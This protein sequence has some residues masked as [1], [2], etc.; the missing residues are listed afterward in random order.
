[1][2]RKY[3]LLSFAWALAVACFGQEKFNPDLALG[4]L[5]GPREN[6]G[7]AAG[8]AV[9]G[10]LKWSGSSGY[11][12]LEGNIPF[13]ATTLTRIASISKPFT[14]VAVMQLVEQN[15]IALD[16]P[17]EHYLPELPGDKGSITVRQLLAHTSGISQYEG[18]KE[19][20]N[21]LHFGSLRE[22][23]AIFIQRP[24]LFEPGSQYFYTTYGY[25]VL[26]RI[27]EAVS[28]MGYREYMKKYVFEVA[29]MGDTD[30]E[31]LREAYPNK[32]CLYHH[33]GRKTREAR[34][35]DLSNRIPGGGF[36]ST[37]EDVL[38]FGNALLEGKLIRRE[39][40]DLMVQ[41]QDV[42]YDGNK[43]GLGWYLYGPAPHE[44]VVI[45]HGGGQSGCTSQLMLVPASKTVVAVLSNT[46]GTYPDIAT[47]T[48][49]L[50]GFSEM[51]K[52]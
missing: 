51:E 40:L 33:G 47:L 48:S 14:A 7:I 25:V 32:S 10:V 27:V 2:T 39:S 44:N 24:L 21:S 1:M 20:E 6:I 35:N 9:D 34:Q 36:Y 12:C 13:A 26:G 29:G 17:I 30:V 5:T 23:M 8:Y 19:I 43:Y 42:A 46:S 3:L 11:A 37:L 16:V 22:A 41:A 50:I 28:S 45:G 31:N 18:E 49:N 15:R 52:E 38:K 4:S